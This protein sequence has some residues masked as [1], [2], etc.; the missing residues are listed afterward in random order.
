ME[1]ALGHFRPSCDHVGLLECA[2][3]GPCPRVIEVVPE[4]GR[5]YYEA[6]RILDDVRN[7]Q[8]ILNES[9]EAKLL[10]RH[11]ASKWEF[12]LSDENLR[13]VYV[14]DTDHKRLLPDKFVFKPYFLRG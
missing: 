13:F 11:D 14:E 8:W 9:G 10:E 2:R 1:Q 7:R 12:K 5:L 3:G 4:R 6:F